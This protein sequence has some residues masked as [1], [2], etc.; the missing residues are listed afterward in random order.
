[1]RE[2]HAFINGSQHVPA[3]ATAGQPDQG[4]GRI[5]VRIRAVQ[6]RQEQQRRI[7]RLCSGNQ[8]VHAIVDVS[9]R[10]FLA[11]GP[12]RQE[13]GNHPFQVAGRRGAGFDHQ[14]LAGTQYRAVMNTSSP[15]AGVVD[16]Y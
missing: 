5:G 6:K 8:L 15:A 10:P 9:V 2:N 7:F 12:V 3:I 4:S 13:L 16:T 14:V 1:M 11:A